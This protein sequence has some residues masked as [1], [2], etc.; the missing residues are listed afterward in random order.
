[1]TGGLW[2][3]VGASGAGKDTVLR[4]LGALAAAPAAP[5]L[6]I[7]RR[8]ITRPAHA[9]EDHH[10]VSEAHFAAMAAAGE[11]A[12]HWRA[13]GLGYGIGREI[14]I[15]LAAGDA[16]VFNGSRAHLGEAYRRYGAAR[17]VLIRVAPAVLAARLAAR[18]RENAA[19]IA[20]RLA[21]HDEL[22]ARMAADPRLVT[23]DNDGTP[24]AAARALYA[25]VTGNLPPSLEVA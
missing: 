16:V 22:D 21:R 14:D 25:L 7:A 17:A 10:P 11:F 12:L 20:A 3:V 6:H 4:R 24:D 19:D 5:R 18:G 15:R 9:S 23:L 1:M 8:W 13:H 2:I